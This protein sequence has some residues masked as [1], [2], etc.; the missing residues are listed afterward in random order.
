MVFEDV[1][2]KNS[3]K[4]KG[5]NHYQK[6]QQNKKKKKRLVNMPPVSHFQKDSGGFLESRALNVKA[7]HRG[8]PRKK[9]RFSFFCFLIT[10]RFLVMI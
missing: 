2:T 6:H 10:F 5:D 7:K 8:I 4:I 1:F 3:T 9:K